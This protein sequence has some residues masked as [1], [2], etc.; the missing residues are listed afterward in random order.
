VIDNAAIPALVDAA[1][2][3][4]V[5]AIVLAQGERRNDDAQDSQDE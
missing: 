3:I 4:A 5:L 1:G 2:G